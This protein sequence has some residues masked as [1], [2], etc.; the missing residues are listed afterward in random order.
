MLVCEFSRERLIGIVL[1]QLETQFV[2][3]IYLH[4]FR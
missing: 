4:A 2:F 1:I 3:Y